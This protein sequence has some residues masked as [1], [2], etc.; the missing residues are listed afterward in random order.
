VSPRYSLE[1]ISASVSAIS[2]AYRFKVLEEGHLDDITDIVV[3]TL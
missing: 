1:V 2:S 3:A